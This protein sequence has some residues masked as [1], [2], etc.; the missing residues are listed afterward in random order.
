ML[1]YVDKYSCEKCG[2]DKKQSTLH[3]HHI[4]PNTKQFNLSD[5]TIHKYGTMVAGEIVDMVKSELDKCI[6]LCS[7]CHAEEHYDFEFDILYSKEIEDHSKN[8]REIQPK[9]DRDFVKNMYDS[10]LRCI[11]IARELNAS[12]GTI[13]DILKSFGLTT[14]AK[15]IKEKSIINKNLKKEQSIVLAEK[16][17]KFNPTIEEATELINIMSCREIGLIY[18]VSHVAVYN[19]LIKMGVLIKRKK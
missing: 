4:L 11:D 19:R 18:S 1:E 5:V 16:R 13:S 17:R 2:Y 7:Q 12:K 8:I 10:G 3:F 6:V 15:I 14:S 9:I